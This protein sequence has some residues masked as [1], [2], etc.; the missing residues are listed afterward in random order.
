METFPKA[1][2][3]VGAY[4]L[5]EK[6]IQLANESGLDSLFLNVSFVGSTLLAQKVGQKL[7]DVIVTQVVLHPPTGSGGE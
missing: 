7:N 6:I 5:C 2:V 1:G 3:T 4:S